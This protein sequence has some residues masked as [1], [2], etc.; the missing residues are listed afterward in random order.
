MAQFDA[1][2]LLRVVMY[3]VIGLLGL[4]VLLVILAFVL[5]SVDNALI[6]DPASDRALEWFAYI[7]MIFCAVGLVC[8]FWKAIRIPTGV[9]VGIYFL[10]FLSTILCFKVY[11]KILYMQHKGDVPVVRTCE[12]TKHEFE[13]E[14]RIVTDR[15]EDG[16]I[17]RER[18]VSRAKFAMNLKFD[19][20]EKE[21]E[22]S[23]DNSLPFYDNVKMGDRA[24]A[25]CVNTHGVL[26]IVGL[27][28][29]E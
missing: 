28:K 17:I 19:D 8:I 21:C 20:E 27:D 1:N 13:I 14:K 22:F 26:F 24:Q 11:E 16:D 15:D 5:P 4:T 2:D 29:E 18:E 25:Q 23:R 6:S 7:F 9:A 3:G 12:V 10:V